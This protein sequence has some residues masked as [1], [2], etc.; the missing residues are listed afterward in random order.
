MFD[1]NKFVHSS[2]SQTC[3]SIKVTLVLFKKVKVETISWR[4]C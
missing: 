1:I 3:T 4:E 2:T